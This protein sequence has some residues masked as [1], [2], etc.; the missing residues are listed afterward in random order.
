MIKKVFIVILVIF[1]WA[2]PSFSGQINEDAVMKI[3]G[4]YIESLD[5]EP[6]FSDNAKEYAVYKDI[7][8]KKLS[9]QSPEDVFLSSVMLGLLH[10]NEST[11]KLNEIKSDSIKA[12]IGISFALCL[13]QEKCQSHWEYMMQVGEYTKV[14]GRAK[15]LKYLE[16]VELLSLTR[17]E[18]FIAYATKIK[19]NTEEVWQEEAID[20]AIERHE[21]IMRSKKKNNLDR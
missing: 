15:S 7:Y 11:A 21:K 8:L 1:I 4:K 18:G 19:N 14:A 6:D 20:V 16:A 5:W 10:V 9:S 12:K 3:T 2:R 13:L 17:H